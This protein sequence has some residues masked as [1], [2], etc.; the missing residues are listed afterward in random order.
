SSG[1]QVQNVQVKGEYDG[2]ILSYLSFAFTLP[3]I[4]STGQYGLVEGQTY[5]L[6]VFSNYQL[7]FPQVTLPAPGSSQISVQY[8]SGTPSQFT[9]TYPDALSGKTYTLTIYNSNP[10]TPSQGVLQLFQQGTVQ[11]QLLVGSDSLSTGYS[12]S[13]T[14]ATLQSPQPGTVVSLTLT[15]SSTTY[16]YFI[17]N[18]SSSTVTLVDLQTGQVYN[19]G[20]SPTSPLSYGGTVSYDG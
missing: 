9:I 11:L 13:N 14:Q 5:Q 10:S 16:N 12:S 17:L 18:V 4:D 8:S 2:K 15:D 20:S 3:Q 7:V 1:Q 6:P 19:V